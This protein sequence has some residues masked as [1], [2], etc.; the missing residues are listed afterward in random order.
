MVEGEK[1]MNEED[2][3]KVG[4]L[5]SVMPSGY[6]YVILEPDELDPKAFSVKMVEKFKKGKHS[7]TVNHI[8]RGILWIIENDI[9][10]ILE[11]GEKDLADEISEARQKQFKNS[12]VLDFFTSIEKTILIFKEKFNCYPKWTG[13]FRTNSFCNFR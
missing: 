12:N 8:L 13:I 10:Y 6:G 2:A 7:L 5:L 9:D 11:V 1:K 3:K 4:E